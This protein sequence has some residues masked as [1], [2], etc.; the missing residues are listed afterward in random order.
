MPLK[1]GL[2][3]WSPPQEFIILQIKINADFFLVTRSRLRACSSSERPPSG[4]PLGSRLRACSSSFQEF[5]IKANKIKPDFFFCARSRLRACPS[6]EEPPSG[7]PLMS[8]PGV[9]LFSLRI[10]NFKTQN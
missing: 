4:V 7:V 3:A 10:H 6:P 2:R 8:A 1:S 9:L 5:M